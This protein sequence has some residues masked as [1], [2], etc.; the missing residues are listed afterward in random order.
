MQHK[1]CPYIDT[2]TK[3]VKCRIMIKLNLPQE[4]APETLRPMR[5]AQHLPSQTTK[6][7]R[8][9]QAKLSP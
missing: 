2:T 3:P 9:N 8:T 4:N 5:R 1:Y 7:P 6:R